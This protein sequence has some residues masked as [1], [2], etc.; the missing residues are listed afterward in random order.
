MAKYD[1]CTSLPV[2]IGGGRLATLWA[3]AAYGAAYRGDDGA[4]YKSN[5]ECWR[6]MVEVPLV[7]E[8]VVPAKSESQRR[9]YDGC[10]SLTVPSGGGRTAI[11]WAGAVCRGD[12]DVS[13]RSDGHVW[14]LMEEDHPPVP[15]EV[16]PAKS[17][18]Q[19]RKETPMC[20][21]VLD[22]FPDAL[23]AVARAS[24]VGND[25]HNPGQ[26][27]HWA[28]DKS[29]DHAD[30]V[31]RHMATRTEIESESGETHAVHAL[32]WALAMVQEMEEKRLGIPP[33]VTPV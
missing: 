24:R 33:R 12:D 13:Y 10:T 2:T 15:E 22:Y 31:V 1:R 4:F 20:T 3:G 16:V 14:R 9:K 8:E 17:E 23:A 25:K 26:P 29:N 30:C 18:S 28:R 7:P 6:Q 27:L 19:R 32:W 5:G 11:L 21:G